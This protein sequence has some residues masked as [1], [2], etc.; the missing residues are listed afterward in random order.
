MAFVFAVFSGG[1]VLAANWYVDSKAT[2][3][4]NGTS[5]GNAWT[6]FSSISWSGIAP[7][8]TI[9]VSGGA[10]S[11]SY[12]SLSIGASGIS[13]KPVTIRIGQEA[14]HN[15]T[16]ILAGIVTNNRSWVTVNGEYQGQ[17][18]IQVTN[19][20]GTGI[21]T[22]SG[23]DTGLVLTYLTV[24]NSGNVKGHHGIQ[25]RGTANEAEISYCAIH[26]NFQDG[27]NAYSGGVSG[28]YGALKIHHN[29]IYRN[30]DDGIQCGGGGVDMYNN[31]IHDQSNWDIGHPD[32]I[33]TS[34][35]NGNYY[36][37]YNNIIYNFSNALVFADPGGGGTSTIS[38]T[39]R[40]IQIYNNVGFK[41]RS[42]PIFSTI[43]VMRG[44][45]LYG[46]SGGT[47]NFDDVVIAN[48]V[49]VDMDLWGID[50]KYKT[51][52]KIS[53]A[54]IANNLIYNCYTDAPG[55]GTALGVRMSYSPST[56]KVY[57]KNN[58]VNAGPHGTQRV[59]WNGAFYTNASLNNAVNSTGN[60]FDVPVFAAYS[61]GGSNQDLRIKSATSPAKDTGA[62][63]STFFKTDKNG[64]TRPQFSAW[65]IGAYE[66][67]A[68]TGTL[69]AKPGIPTGLTVQ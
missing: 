19:P 17:R 67:P 56:D 34:G 22:G 37:I 28:K 58:L 6:G 41:D 54:V 52:G 42:N 4:N 32:G 16:A 30:G 64:V 49:I 11:K 65:D 13:G 66:F 2:G 24:K 5:W 7:G 51:A 23:S 59:Y 48:N 33:Q 53:N 38:A 14:G 8:D 45:I 25:I 29:E 31:V 69:S 1:E 47:I 39:F 3:S 50:V 9:Y 36:R 20:S 55:S 27:I 18:R 63:L 40:H 43:N 62:D 35:G 61:E 44:I 57:L 26:N 12:G 68:G 15:G 46:D 10:T 21:A 60:R